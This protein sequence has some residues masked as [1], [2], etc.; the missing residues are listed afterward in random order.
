MGEGRKQGEGSLEDEARHGVKSN[1]NGMGVHKRRVMDL[2]EHRQP[3]PLL[4]YGS[5]ADT[6][7]LE[8]VDCARL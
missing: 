5:H 1:W 6:Q 4:G 2:D 3:V 8:I 7:H